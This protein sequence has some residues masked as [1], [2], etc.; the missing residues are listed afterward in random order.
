LPKLVNKDLIN[1]KED[2]MMSLEQMTPGIKVFVSFLRG[3]MTDFLANN[4]QSI[5]EFQDFLL[6]NK[7]I[8]QE[9]RDQV[10]K[11]DNSF[12][13]I[14]KKVFKVDDQLLDE[15]YEKVSNLLPELSN[16]MGN[17]GESLYQ[18][19]TLINEV[20]NASF[21]ELL[22]LFLGYDTKKNIN[23]TQ[24]LICFEAGRQLLLLLKGLQGIKH[25][26][27]MTK[28]VIDGDFQSVINQFFGSAGGENLI[29]LGNNILRVRHRNFSGEKVIIEEKP[30]KIFP[31]FLRKSFE[32]SSEKID[33]FL[34]VNI[35]LNAPLENKEAIIPYYDNLIKRLRAYMGKNFPQKTVSF[36]PQKY[37]GTLDWI[38]GNPPKIDGTRRGSEGNRIVRIKTIVNFGKET[39]ELVFYPYVSL[40]EG[41]YWGWQE[42]I[43]D[44]TKY[45]IRR[46]HAGENGIPS[47]YDLLY[48]PEFYPHHYRYKKLT[49]SYFND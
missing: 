6:N 41:G 5:D 37:Y 3:V 25:F 23:E 39:I 13:E 40:K 38:Q 10:K 2:L 22:M 19:F 8:L 9:K 36:G 4:N 29:T 20:N 47:L 49:S 34:C 1:Q 17:N 48:P 31:S 21:G 16:Q 26:K 11:L 7:I 43:I 28:E 46:I 44:D 15:T 18:D 35:V 33:D 45:L 14:L 12:R 30:R 27:K 32:T 24:K 42:K